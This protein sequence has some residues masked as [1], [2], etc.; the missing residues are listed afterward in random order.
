MAAAAVPLVSADISAA[1]ARAATRFLTARVAEARAS[2]VGRGASVALRFV[3]TAAGVT[4]RPYVDGDGDGVLTADIADGT[5]A[6]MGPAVNLADVLSGVHIAFVGGRAMPD[7]LVPG[8]AHLFSFSP[9]STATS[10][11]IYVRGRDGSQ[12]AV[13]ILGVTA[14][15]R[16][17]RYLPSTDSWAE[18]E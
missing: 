9:M 8:R 14:R 5:D 16:V 15:A 7:V 3:E 6:P 13:R 17:A 12:W 18:G 4:V 1:R 2:A 10:G 11:S